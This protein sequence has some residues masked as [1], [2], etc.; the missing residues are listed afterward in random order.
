M[1]FIRHSDGNEL[2]KMFN[3]TEGTKPMLINPPHFSADPFIAAVAGMIGRGGSPVP[4]K[5]ADGLY[6][7]SHWNVENMV[8]GV[9]E[10]WRE[11]EY[12]EP[13]FPEYGVVDTPE[14]LL[15]KIDLVSIPEKVFVSFVRIDR[16]QN[17]AGKGGGWRWHKW[18]EY[19]G[20]Q[21]PQCEY[22][23]DEP[24]IETVYTF[25][26]HEMM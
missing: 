3:G 7:A 15:E 14:Q 21:D 4:A 16:D 9:R 18:G 12:S 26:I 23:D 13:P 22:I 6:L 24:N 10:R 1:N 25:S 17:N 5:I 19:I 8:E 11:A 2:L 20:D